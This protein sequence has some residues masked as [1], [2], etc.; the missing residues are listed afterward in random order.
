MRK[1][2]IAYESARKDPTVNPAKNRPV[3]ITRVFNMGHIDWTNAETVRALTEKAFLDEFQINISL[4]ADRLCPPL[5]N[6]LNYITWMNSLIN[7]LPVTIPTLS[8]HP[9][10]SFST[11]SLVPE[12]R[13]LDIGTG[14]S[15]VYALLGAKL[16]GWKF[17]A[18]DVDPYALHHVHTTLARN[19]TLQSLIVPVQVPPC[20]GLQQV[21]SDRYIPLLV[22]PVTIDSPSSNA[23]MDEDS[24]P[25]EPSHPSDGAHSLPEMSLRQLLVERG[26]GRGMDDTSETLRGP[27]RA[28]LL[29]SPW[30]QVVT[31]CEHAF[32]AV[33][34]YGSGLPMM[35]D[36][37]E[38]VL[39]AS[40]CNPPFFDL[41][42]EVFFHVY[43]LQF[44][45]NEEVLPT[46]S[47]VIWLL[48]VDRAQ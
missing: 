27:V 8:S 25:S 31:Q 1:K 21:L 16:H 18:S 34:S 37:M 40:M 38:P 22:A 46:L 32:V 3:Y 36:W 5:P 48:T 12:V 2:T 6:R 19:P 43:L 47:R 15:C 13:I 35:S 29:C 28:A 45:S 30:A 4:P 7:L 39:H 10:S 9:P 11:N 14:A 20:V 17:L 33:S 23:K 41:D 26:T 42:E 24:Q 44:L